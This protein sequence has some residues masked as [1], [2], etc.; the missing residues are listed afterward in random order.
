MI[1]IGDPVQVSEGIGMAFRPADTALR[2][3]FNAAL[4][5]TRDKG[6]WDE[7]AK[8]GA[9]PSSNFMALQLP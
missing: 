8:N 9:R 5:T 2:D 1:N 3:E 7:L 6:I 4:K